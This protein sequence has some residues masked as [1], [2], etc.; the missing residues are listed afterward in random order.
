MD[1][2]NPEG[3]VLYRE[4]DTQDILEQ[5]EQLEYAYLLDIQDES[6]LIAVAQVVE[7]YD[8]GMVDSRRGDSDPFDLERT[9]LE[10]VDFAKVDLGEIEFEKVD[11]EQTGCGV[12]LGNVALEI[13]LAYMGRQAVQ[14]VFGVLM[15]LQEWIE[16]QI[17]EVKTEQGVA[18]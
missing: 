2:N 5:P 6:H 3:G 17:L 13:V 15:E 10:R 7:T 9:I 12:N 11:L 1:T 16:H 8:L 4:E 18:P 14:Q